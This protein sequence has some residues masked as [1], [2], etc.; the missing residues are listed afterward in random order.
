MT[1]LSLVEERFAFDIEKFDKLE[2]QLL[3]F[4]NESGVANKDNFSIMTDNYAWPKHT[5][6]EDEDNSISHN[7]FHHFVAISNSLIYGVCA[8]SFP[9]STERDYV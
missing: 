4:F 5:K 1:V 8:K 9:V 2:E 6:L 3:F 7:S